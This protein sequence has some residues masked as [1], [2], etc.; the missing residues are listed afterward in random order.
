MQYTY[1]ISGLEDLE[2]GKPV[3]MLYAELLDLLESQLTEHDWH[4]LELLKMKYDDPLVDEL[5]EQADRQNI[6]SEQD[7]RTQLLYEYG[8]HAD[9]AFVR[10][11]FEFNLNMNNVLAATICLK[12]GYDI[13][14]S[15]VGDNDVAEILRKGSISKNANLAVAVPDLKEIVAIADIDNL[16]EREKAIDKLRW[17]WLEEETLFCYFE[18]DN[19][20]AYFLKATILQRWAVLNKEKGEQVF[21]AIV[22][23]MK[24]DVKF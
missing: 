3:K 10:K 12:H 15:I 2:L 22:D 23:D 21:R 5:L 8:M 13:Q 11:W 18:L 20:L 17:Q 16:L 19:V 14:K 7:Y 6:L 9:N 24:R 1:L 4:L